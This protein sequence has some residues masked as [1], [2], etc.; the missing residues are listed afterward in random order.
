MADDHWVF[1]GSMLKLELD[2]REVLG[3][4]DH[5]VKRQHHFASVLALTWTARDVRDDMRSRLPLYFT[6]RNKRTAKGIQFRGA[7]TQQS[8]PFSEVGSL[9]DY[10]RMQAMGGWKLADNQGSVAVPVRAR[11]PKTVR[12]T[13][14]KWPGSMIKRA[15]PGRIIIRDLGKG[16]A[17]VFQVK[18]R[19]GSGGLVFQWLLVDRVRIQPIWPWKRLVEARVGHSYERLAMKALKRALE[20]AKRRVKRT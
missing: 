15:K 5:E 14:S 1:G 17:G 2:A 7:S 4:L 3:Y 20:T 10:M 9:D 16:A 11:R 13:R 6:I 18:G 8:I 12:T 19:G